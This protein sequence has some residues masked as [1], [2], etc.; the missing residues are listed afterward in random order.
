[1]MCFGGVRVCF[2][3]QVDKVL[4]ERLRDLVFDFRSIIAVIE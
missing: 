4:K 3:E 2:S 1:M